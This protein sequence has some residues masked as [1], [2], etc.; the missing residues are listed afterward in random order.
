MTC[1]DISQFPLWAHEGPVRSTRQ[2]D[3]RTLFPERN[4]T[5]PLLEYDIILF[6]RCDGD[7]EPRP[8]LCPHQP[9]VPVTTGWGFSVLPSRLGLNRSEES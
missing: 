4:F 1:C 7:G 9:L 3:A 2:W 6:I 5:V 8:S